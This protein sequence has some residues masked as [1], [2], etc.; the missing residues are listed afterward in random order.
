MLLCLGRQADAGSDGTRIRFRSRFLRHR[1][2]S[3]CRP[4][5][6]RGSEHVRSHRAGMRQR[7]RRPRRLAQRAA[8]ASPHGGSRPW[9]RGGDRHRLSFRGAPGKTAAFFLPRSGAGSLERQGYAVRPLGDRRPARSL[10]L[11]LLSRHDPFLPGR[12]HAGDDPRGK[13]CRHPGKPPCAWND[14]DRGLRRGAHRD[15]QADLLHIR[16][17]SAP[18]RRAR[19]AFRAG[20]AIRILQGRAQAVR[21]AQDRPRHR[22]AFRRRDPRNLR[23][24]A[25]PQGF[26]H[27]AARTDLAR[28]GDRPWRQDHRHRQDRRYLRP[29]RHLGNA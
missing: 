14:G 16:G 20:T 7:H 19:G 3:R 9:R 13:R 23:T 2:G 4:L 26:F 18:D 12:T 1:R 29:S 24:D 8:R 11:G 17:F 21:P 6:R 10:R 28:P 27:T 22:P 25:Q 15:R 5:R